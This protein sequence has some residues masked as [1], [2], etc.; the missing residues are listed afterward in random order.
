MRLIG[1]AILLTV[2]FVL[3]PLATGAQQSVKIPRVGC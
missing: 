1:L 2:S 3:A